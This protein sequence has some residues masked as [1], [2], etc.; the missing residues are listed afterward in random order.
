MGLKMGSFHPGEP[1]PGVIKITRRTNGYSSTKFGGNI[2]SVY[3]SLGLITV[4]IQPQEQEMKKGETSNR[5]L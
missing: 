1:E 4:G 3:S 2:T 5:R